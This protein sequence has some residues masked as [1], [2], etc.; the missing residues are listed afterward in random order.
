MSFT[1]KRLSFLKNRHVGE[2]CVLVA[3]GPSL[4]EMDLSFLR[5]ENTIG[6]NKIYLGIKR[7]NFYPRYYVAVN[8]VVIEQS[9]AQIKSLNAVK[10]LGQAAAKGHFKEDALTY[11]VP[12]RAYRRD[13]QGICRSV[14]CDDIAVDG[15]YEGWT[16]TFAALQIAYYLGFS[17]VVLIGLDHRFDFKGES[18]ERQLLKGQDINHFDPNYFGGGQAWDTPD[19][20]NSEASYRVAREFYE[21]RGRN[22]TDAT[23]NGAC[24]VFQKADYRSLFGLT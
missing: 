24:H 12:T 7:F 16:V 17:E 15:L 6:L 2:R 23:V 9:V 8:P 5:R 19:L 4:N 14:F 3:N 1:N 21:A 18:N 20:E 11:L 22:I 10:F 13:S